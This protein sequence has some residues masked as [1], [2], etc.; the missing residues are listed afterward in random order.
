VGEKSLSEPPNVTDEAFSLRLFE[1][2]S[3]AIRHRILRRLLKRGARIG[4]NSPTVPFSTQP[5]V[6]SESKK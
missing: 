4:S 1:R 3:V 5:S 6:F 2:R